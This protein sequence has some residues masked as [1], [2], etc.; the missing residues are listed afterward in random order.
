MARDF[1]QADPR[2]PELSQVAKL[3][4]MGPD[5]WLLF[6]AGQCYCLVPLTFLHPHPY[7]RPP[8]DTLKKPCWE[9]SEG[10]L[11]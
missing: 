1:S 5:L 4:G 11:C 7:L 9:P 3:P 8:S 2:H 6:E 10:N